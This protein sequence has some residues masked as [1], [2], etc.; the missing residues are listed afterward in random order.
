MANEKVYVIKITNETGGRKVAEKAGGAGGIQNNTNTE[1]K[2]GETSEKATVQK[3]INAV[4]VYKQVKSVLNNHVS[5]EVSKVQLRTGS[6]DAQ[7]KANMFYNMGN[8]GIS[9][10]E[11]VVI[12]AKFG[13]GIGAAIA[14]VTS[15]INEA[16]DMQQ[17]W[18]KYN[19]EKEL[20]TTK[21]DL[22]AQ[23]TTVSGS[24]YQNA[25]Q[26]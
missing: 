9:I 7:Q 12:G 6:S 25:T 16:M 2:G 26:M 24:R 21:Q 10:V 17:T 19:L 20:E 1:N 11:N 8:K 14:A 22:A 23:R 13:G 18:D 15:V 5:H 3:A 4:F